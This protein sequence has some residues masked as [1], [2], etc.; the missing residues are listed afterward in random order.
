MSYASETTPLTRASLEA[1]GI[2]Y[3][4]HAGCK[5]GDEDFFT[6]LFERL[7]RYFEC[8][9][10][11]L[12]AFPEYKQPIGPPP[13]NGQFLPN[14][15]EWLSELLLDCRRVIPT[16]AVKI[17]NR[18]ERASKPAHLNAIVFKDE[19]HAFRSNLERDFVEQQYRELMRQARD[20]AHKAG[21]LR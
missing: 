16:Y 3:V 11:P 5:L 12:A 21:H 4:D 13:Y 19:D 8:S 1:Q 6:K 15:I 9:E 10:L 7:R 14:Q 2:F 17:L 18:T 20:V